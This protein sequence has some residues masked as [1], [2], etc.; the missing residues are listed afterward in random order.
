MQLDCNV[1]IKSA[2]IAW[3]LRVVK[4]EKTKSDAVEWCKKM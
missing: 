2:N 3:N 1:T 4:N